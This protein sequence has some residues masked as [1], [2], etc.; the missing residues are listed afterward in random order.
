MIWIDPSRE[1]VIAM[2]SAWPSAENEELEDH[3]MAFVNALAGEL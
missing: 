2:H 1:I 3:R